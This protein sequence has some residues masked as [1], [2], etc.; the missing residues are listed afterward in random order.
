MKK[1]FKHRILSWR[2]NWHANHQER[3]KK[4][5]DYAHAQRILLLYEDTATGQRSQLEQIIREL[6]AA[7]K[8]VITCC[9]SADDEAARTT[10]PDN[11]TH[12]LYKKD[13]DLTGKP[14]KEI[15]LPILTRQFDIVM[16]LT[17]SPCLPLLYVLLYANASCKIGLQHTDNQ[18]L[19]F[20]ISYPKE[21]QQ[22]QQPVQPSVSNLYRNIL[23]YQK[24]IRS[25]E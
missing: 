23:F 2:A 10:Q 9:F 18:L 25:S 12:F 21:K 7:G 20:I 6:T 24:N 5:V 14:K 15:L 22:T 13:I 19:D 11:N 3:I 17:L 16:D 8:Q 1:T 4:Y